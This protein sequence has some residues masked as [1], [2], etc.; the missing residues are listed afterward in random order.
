MTPFPW[1]TDEVIAIFAINGRTPRWRRAQRLPEKVQTGGMSA[2][3]G[4]RGRQ[5]ALWRCKEQFHA[6]V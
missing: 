3:G 6:E 4:E 2:K 1:A 5:E